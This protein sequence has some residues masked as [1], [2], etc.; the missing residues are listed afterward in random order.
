MSETLFEK[1]KRSGRYCRSVETRKK[2]NWFLEAIRSG[3]V[4]G[5]CRRLGVVPKTYYLWW[6]RFRRSGFKLEALEPKSQRPRRSPSK[7]KPKA[8]RLIRHYRLEYHYGP[9]RIQMYM[10][11]NHGILIA[12]STIQRVIEREGLRLRRNK[13]PSVNRHTR[14]YTLP[15][16]GSLQM[17]IKY[18]PKKIHDEQY[19]VYNAIDDCT[20]W[21]I[22][23]LYR[24]I[25]ITEAC[26]FLRYVHQAAPFSVRSVQLD[27]DRAFTYR[28]TPNCFDKRHPLSSRAEE[29][30]IQLKFIP[31]GEKELQ[32]KVER[33]NRTDEDEF[34]WK[35]PYHSFALL[36]KN[37][38][39]WAF[40]YNHYRR[41]K[42]LGWKT[43]AEALQSVLIHQAPL[44]YQ[45]NGQRPLEWRYRDGPRSP[46]K[47]HWNL[48]QYLE[49]WRPDRS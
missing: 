31:P 13:K 20:R 17:D 28:L 27:N 44:G 32:G 25:G 23:K 48:K 33:L 4:R 39:D 26:D 45:I 35:I 40:E 47:T 2:I 49:A 19:F 6:N 38:N 42:S 3:D 41:H 46:P 34:F 24:K 7:T 21:R 12:R 9:E 30:G 14:R 22:S 10:K 37:L 11:L 43:P 29:L 5:T 15:V 8:V 36:E 18:V 1:V 16:P